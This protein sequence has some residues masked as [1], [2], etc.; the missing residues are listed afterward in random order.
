MYMVEHEGEITCLDSRHDAVN[1]AQQLSR[2][3]GGRVV[4]SDEEGWVRMVYREG[5][6]DNFQFESPITKSRR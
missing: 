6:L 3:R 1:A 5:V 4:V 2:Q